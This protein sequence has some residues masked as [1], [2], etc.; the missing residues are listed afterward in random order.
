[1]DDKQGTDD[2]VKRGIED[3]DTEAQRFTHRA[4]P[5][6]EPGPEELVKRTLEDDEDDTEGQKVT[7]R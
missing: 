4:I 7:R 1:M 2:V 5:G 6:D 3:D